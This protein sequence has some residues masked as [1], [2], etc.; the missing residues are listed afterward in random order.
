[1]CVPVEGRCGLCSLLPVFSLF[2]G[3]FSPLSDLDFYSVVRIGSIDMVRLHISVGLL[4]PGSL[5]CL[6]FVSDSK[7]GPQPGCDVASRSGGWFY[8]S[9]Y[10]GVCLH[11]GKVS[12]G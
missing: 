7:F 5:D 10:S 9:E 8:K 3:Y 6:R 2:I 12:T 1:M 4:H 11:H